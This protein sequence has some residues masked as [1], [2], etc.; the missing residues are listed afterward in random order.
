MNYSATRFKIHLFF[1]EKSRR[2]VFPIKF[3]GLPLGR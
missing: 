2:I 1:K 3:V